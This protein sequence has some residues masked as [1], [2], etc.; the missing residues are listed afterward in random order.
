MRNLAS[1]AL[2]SL[3]VSLPSSARQAPVVWPSASGEAPLAVASA[4]DVDGD[5]REDCAVFERAIAG[6]SARVRVFSSAN[7]STLIDVPAPASTA[8]ELASIGDVDLDGH[9][10]LALGFFGNVLALSG[11]NGGTLWNLNVVGEPL[12]IAVVDDRDQDGVRDLAVGRTVAFGLGSVDFVSGVGG[13]LL[14]S[15]VPPA[16]ST[17]VFGC[18]VAAVGDLDF[19][20]VIDLA[21]GDWRAIAGKGVVHVLSGANGSVLS[22]MSGPTSFLNSSGFGLALAAIGDVDLDGVGDLAVGAPSF[23]L[24]GPPGY[25]G[26]GMTGAV[27]VHSLAGGTLLREIR[28][29]GTLGF[30]LSVEAMGDVDLDGRGD[31][32]VGS[33]LVR[34]G[35]CHYFAASAQVIS[36]YTG[37]LIHTDGEVSNGMVARIADIDGDGL[38]EIFAGSSVSTPPSSSLIPL[39]LSPR[40]RVDCTP[41][42]LPGACAPDLFASGQSFSSSTGLM[43]LGERMAAGRAARFMWSSNSTVR[44]LGFGTL[45]LAAPIGAS[46]MFVA[47]GVTGLP[48]SG[49]AS[50]AVSSSTL[51]SLVTPGV[52]LYAQLWQRQPTAAA[53]TTATLSSSIEIPIWP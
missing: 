27:L 44:P 36:P 29:L 51:A 21:V 9:D 28:T 14:S 20:G 48:C 34:S 50:F 35:C 49:T 40:V 5:G 7:G 52:L 37:L 53:S 45:C 13:A 12:S 8:V 18:A 32:L 41:V 11:A 16:G 43:L 46:P 4:G 3:V 15:V 19:D 1:L 22:S 25:E 42:V 38:A 31:L 39:R 6:P 30:G 26:P 33:A 10:D 47:G 24:G 23:Q 17:E 2:A